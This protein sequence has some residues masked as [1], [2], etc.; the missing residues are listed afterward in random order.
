MQPFTKADLSA[1]FGI[2]GIDHRDIAASCKLGG[3][4]K[5][6]LPNEDKLDLINRF[7]FVGTDGTTSLVEEDDFDTPS[8][9]AASSVVWGVVGGK[10]EVH[11]VSNRIVL[12][13]QDR[14][15]NSGF[16]TMLELQ[17]GIC[18]AIAMKRGAFDCTG[19]PFLDS[20]C[21]WVRLG[22][23]PWTWFPRKTPVVVCDLP[24]EFKFVHNMPKESRTR[25]FFENQL[26][27]AF[28]IIK[29]NNI[30]VILITHRARIQDVSK[31]F[32]SQVDDA[33]ES[34]DERMKALVTLVKTKGATY[35]G[36][37]KN[38]T[39]FFEYAKDKNF[40]DYDLLRDWMD[41]IGKPSPVFNVLPSELNNNWDAMRFHYTTWGYQESANGN[42]YFAPSCWVRI[43]YTPALD[44]AT[45]HK[46]TMLEMALGKGHSVALTLAHNECNLYKSKHLA[47][48][49]HQLNKTRPVK[50]RIG[51]NVKTMNKTRLS[52]S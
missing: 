47:L 5:T 1:M 40:T 24:V 32:T 42:K 43:G 6:V 35:D 12:Q 2:L 31:E 27:R 50:Q 29:Q 28:Q 16:R 3:T 18:L 33:I 22:L 7:C 9:I 30:A 15:S 44:P 46:V 26:K 38:L 41:A 34:L 52:R 48:L 37:L 4:E 11:P 10:T 45:A 51:Y 36:N 8:L 39:L 23:Q 17:Q 49:K 25:K 13:G 19:C 20:G 14:E 21:N